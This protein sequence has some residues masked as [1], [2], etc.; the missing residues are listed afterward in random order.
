MQNKYFDA[1]KSL[2]FFLAGA[3]LKFDRCRP[4]LFIGLKIFNI[5]F[6]IFLSPTIPAIFLLV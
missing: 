6:R 4:M 3:V 2:H 1:T 5:S